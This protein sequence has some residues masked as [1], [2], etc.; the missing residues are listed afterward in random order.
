MIDQK[1]AGILWCLLFLVT[2]LNAWPETTATQSGN[3]SKG[4]KIASA[5]STESSKPKFTHISL[6]R[7]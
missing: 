3:L 4:K 1:V 6:K 2:P 7:R 5:T